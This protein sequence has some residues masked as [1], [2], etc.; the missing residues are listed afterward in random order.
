MSSD[1]LITNARII[2]RDAEIN[3]SV[4][5]RDG[6]IA[7]IDDTP[8]AT[9]D[10]IDFGGDYLMPGLV[11]LHTDNLE[12][13]F[14]PR[15]GVRWP[16]KLA[17]INHDAQVAAAGITTVMDAVAVGDVRDGS[18]RMEILREMI[19]AIEASQKAGMLRAEHLLHLRCEVSFKDLMGLVEPISSLSWLKLVSIMDHTPGQRQFVKPE[20]YREYYQGK[21]GMTDEQMDAFMATQIAAAEANGVRNR[22]AVVALC[23]AKGLP[24]ASHDD[25]TPDHVAEA[26][27]D[28]MVVA[29]FPTTHEAA[30]LSRQHGMKVMMGGPNVV[31]GGSHSGNISAK[32]LAEKGHL[33][34]LSSD[35][36]PSSML[37]S[38]FLLPEQIP[39]VSLAQAV[40]M[41]SANPA[42]AVGLTDRGA[43]ETGKRADLLR[44]ATVDATPVVRSVWR[45]GHRV[46]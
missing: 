4:L 43:I 20:K 6:V 41:A 10:A 15:P 34:I 2:G 7:E 12:K 36:V 5:V 22:R 28:G 31:R 39:G 37:Q 46:M 17:V 23:K 18:I 32:S 27:S 24:L 33:D 16:A 30:N 3:G 1:L 45:A 11:E 35:Y 8:T 13:H 25:A 26:A 29:E 9:R 44:V 14:A 21:F 42:D 40:A 19:A 38:V